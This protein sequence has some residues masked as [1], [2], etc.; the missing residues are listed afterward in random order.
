MVCSSVFVSFVTVR[1]SRPG[2]RGSWTDGGPS[3]SPAA[4]GLRAAGRHAWSEAQARWLTGCGGQHSSNT[5]PAPGGSNTRITRTKRHSPAH[6]GT[7]A[8]MAS[9]APDRP[10]AG[11][12]GCGAASG[13]GSRADDR[14]SEKRKVDSS[15]LSLT[16]RRS[17]RFSEGL[18]HVWALGDLRIRV[19]HSW[20]ACS[21][22]CAVR[23]VPGW[24]L[25]VLVARSGA[26]SRC[27]AGVFVVVRGAG[28]GVRRCCDKAGQGFAAPAAG[29]RGEAG[30]GAA[31]VVVLASVPCGG[32]AL[33]AGDGQAGGEQHPGC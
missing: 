6:V 16:T 9:Q 25:C 20:R 22:G 17:S 21:T 24:L 23:C 7:P 10:I 33:V 31:G 30:G 3:R 26:C 19:R 28:Y 5:R 11:K 18:I 29:P 12:A 15:I 14:P 13:R 27:W 2:R 8:K 1:H 32:D 4:A